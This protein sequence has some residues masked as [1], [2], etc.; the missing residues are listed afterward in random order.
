MSKTIRFD[1]SEASGKSHSIV[2]IKQSIGVTALDSDKKEE[3]EDGYEFR[4]TDGRHVNHAGKGKYK[5]VDLPENIPI[6]TDDPIAP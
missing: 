2:G 5:I 1:A 3:L 4:T 6:T